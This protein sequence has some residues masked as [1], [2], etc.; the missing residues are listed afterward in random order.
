MR[1]VYTDEALENLDE[2]LATIASNYPTVYEAF[3]NRLQSVV[4]RISAWPDSAQE[5][6]ERSGVRVVPLIRYPYKVFYRNT[7][8]VIEILYIHHAARDP[9]SES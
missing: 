4:K 8:S 3:Q 5:V 1:V 7:G 2:I 6:A 9:L